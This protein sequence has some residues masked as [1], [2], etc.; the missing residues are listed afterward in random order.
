MKLIKR[1]EI[2]RFS[3]VEI[4]TY[5]WNQYSGSVDQKVGL[6]CTIALRQLAL[7]DRALKTRRLHPPIA[8]ISSNSDSDALALAPLM[9]F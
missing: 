6:K 3:Y 5:Q 2:V 8:L 4:P 1:V 9:R 7:L